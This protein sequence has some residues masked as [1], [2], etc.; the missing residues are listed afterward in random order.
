MGRMQEDTFTLG[1]AS[2][3]LMHN[4]VQSTNIRDQKHILSENQLASF[5]L[6]FAQHAKIL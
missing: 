4:Q 2:L 1:R 3:K 5:L 6:G